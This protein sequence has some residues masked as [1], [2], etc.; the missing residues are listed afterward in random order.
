VTTTY[1][2]AIVGYGP[3]GMVAAS[4]LGRL[5]VSVVVIERWPGLYGLPRLTHIDDETARTIQASGDAQHALRDS[6]PAESRWVNAKEET[7]LFIPAPEGDMGYTSHISMYQ[8]DIESAIDD[9]IRQY[10]NVTLK[11]GWALV[12]IQQDADGVDL[13]I[14][15][16]EGRA[17]AGSDHET[18]RAQ[19]VIAADGS[20]SRVR[21]LLDVERDDLG[22]SEKWANVDTEWRHTP[23][24]SFGLAKVYCDPERGHMF[25]GIGTRRLR[26]EYAVLATD[27]PE[28]SGTEE[29]SWQFL[30]DMHGLTPEDLAIVRRVVYNFESR[31]AQTWRVGR[32]FLAGDAAH[33][34]PPYLGQGACSGI[35]DANNLAWKLHLRLTGRAGDE[36]LDSYELERRPHV[37]VITRMS[38][39]LGEVANMTDGVKAAE[40]D[41]AF[42]AGHMPPAPEFPPVLDGVLQPRRGGPAAGAIGF[43]TPQG[44]LREG[45]RQALGDEILGYRFAL[46][47]RIDP[48][49][50]L[51]AA[52]EKVLDTLGVAVLALDGS[53]IDVDG[54]YGAFLDRLGAEAA[55]VRPDFLLFGVADTRIAIGDLIDELAS[56][57]HL[58]QPTTA[59]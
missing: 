11:Q 22:F 45:E 50:D 7:L 43:P 39:G 55:L 5:G 14:G 3:T 51:S 21:E 40:R 38:I 6:S 29:E 32:V 18:V 24:P 10:P 49:A 59:R 12:G 57:V 2:V 47:S 46:I 36:L 13:T 4:L 25:M 27:D 20:K 16:W 1:E 31:V 53:V 41:A 54:A 17:I 42:K 35:R 58:L 19:Y 26:F 34:M 37:D 28:R 56:S 33:T 52:Q 48:R 44:H 30:H 23:D 9:R 15:R 8:P